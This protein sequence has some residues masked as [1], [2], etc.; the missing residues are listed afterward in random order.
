MSS[1]PVKS[2]NLDLPLAIDKSLM[3]S[4]SLRELARESEL[5]PISVL[6]IKVVLIATSDI[7]IDT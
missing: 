6:G 3:I 7:A 5:V 4:P 2:F 1:V